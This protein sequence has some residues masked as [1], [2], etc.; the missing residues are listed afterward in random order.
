MPAGEVEGTP[1]KLGVVSVGKAAPGPANGA[2]PGSAQDAGSG[3]VEGGTHETDL[4]REQ[5]TDTLKSE[6]GAKAQSNQYNRGRRA[7]ENSEVQMG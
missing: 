6:E 7:G 5:S 1:R 4:N 3:N 2:Q